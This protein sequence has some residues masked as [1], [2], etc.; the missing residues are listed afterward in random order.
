MNRLSIIPAVTLAALA[1]CGGQSDSAKTDA[2]QTDVQHAAAITLA[3][4]AA[5][6]KTDSILRAHNIDAD[7][8]EQMMY[9]IAADSAKNAE[10]RRLTAR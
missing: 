5:P 4:Q 10:Y 9:V 2:A 6:T 7:Q 1:A 8:L 3:V